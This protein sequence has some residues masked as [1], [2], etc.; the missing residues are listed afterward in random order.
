MVHTNWEEGTDQYGKPTTIF[1]H[2]GGEEGIA[3][4]LSMML[5][6]DIKNNLN[7]KLYN[8]SNEEVIEQQPINIEQQPTMTLFDLFGMSIEQP[9]P[10][11]RRNAPAATSKTATNKEVASSLFTQQP[12][13][14]A[15]P[16]I[17]LT[18][19]LW[20]GEKLNFYKDGII[21]IDNNENVGYLKDGQRGALM[22]HP[23]DFDTSKT[24]RIKA[25]IA[26][27][28]T[29]FSLHAAEQ[30]LKKEHSELRADLNTHYNN[31][32]K[33]YGNLNDASNE[34]VIRLDNAGREIL[35]IERVQEGEFV[36]ADIFHHPIA[37]STT[38]N[39]SIDNAYDALTASLNEYGTVNIEYMSD[40][41]SMSAENIT[42]ELKGKIYYNPLVDNYEVVDRFIS[43]NVIE[44]AEKIDSYLLEN[45][46]DTR[47]AE[48]LTALRDAAPRAI[49]FDELDFN[50]GER[51]IPAGIYSKF[52]SE[53]FGTDVKIAYSPE[54]DDFS[55]KN[56]GYNANIYDKYCVRT[57]Y[58]TY[59]GTALLGYALVNSVPD[60]TKT[61]NKG[62]DNE[63]KV[64]DSEA[65][66]KA[67]TKIDA[68][69]NA[70]NDWL[71]KQSP[72]FKDRLADLYN[73]K[74]NCYVRPAYNGTHQT[75]PKLD[76]KALGINDLYDSQKNAIWML[77]QNGGG[78][79]DHEVGTGKT[80]IMC[81][82]AHEMKRLGIVNKPMI[83][84]LKAN[85]HEIA[86]TYKKAYPNAKVLYPGKEDFTKQ[87]RMKIF[88]EIK[89]NDWDVIIIT[90][91]QFGK[92]PQSDDVK[93]S[94]FEAELQAVEDNLKVIEEQGKDIS[95]AM[96]KGLE[97]RKANLST[98][99]DELNHS[100]NTRTDEIV[101]F[102]QMGIDHIFVDESHQFKNL[103]FTTR[104]VLNHN[105]LS[106]SK[107]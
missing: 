100:I 75:F 49:T 64:K 107:I 40:L 77:M 33:T 87:N 97:K 18:P 20:S 24:E 50:F 52:A 37:F 104:Y 102:K 23:L 8:A 36:K 61:I 42:D 103:M 3:K 35:S 17:D 11:R 46:H 68:I 5:N 9:K 90:H 57:D 2:S 19:R 29:Y 78:I 94:L 44:K 89:N 99:L 72:E 101:D 83:I 30:L 6:D 106:I 85:V 53:L 32:Q 7:L 96:L 41:C 1:K 34:G 76:F 105:H 51:W 93:K 86:D 4:D 55:V 63:R 88:Y 60:I 31:F 79:V 58:R 98:K 81:A 26:I 22:F 47:A 69:R 13:A 15:E 48:S 16:Q 84:G 43:G 62:T 21:I 91:D 80:L 73:K 65:I 39:Y 14:A 25:Y 66:Q 95:G 12:I 54:L 38:D 28:D 56:R 74:F 92:I 82:A 27:R 45:P 70:F 59:D 10:K 67:N 71:I